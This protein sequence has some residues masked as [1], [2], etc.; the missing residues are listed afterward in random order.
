MSKDGWVRWSQWDGGGM[1]GVG[2]MPLRSVP[3]QLRKFGEAAMGVLVATGADHVLYGVKLYDDDGELDEVKFY[4]L[5]MSE[6]E[7][8]KDVASIPGVVVYALHKR[9]GLSVMPKEEK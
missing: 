1:V 7:F 3:E 8:E 6:E 4:Q 9:D 5:P 2:Q